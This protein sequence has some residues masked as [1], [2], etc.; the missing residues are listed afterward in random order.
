MTPQSPS[1]FAVIGHPIAHS[2][3]PMIHEAFAHQCGIALSYTRIDA[4]PDLFES[5]VERFFSENGRGLNVTVPFKERAF[6][7]A[8]SHLSERAREAGAV[9]TLWTRDGQLHGCNTDGVGLVRDLSRLGMLKPGQRI[10][11]L[12]AGGAARGV[13]GPLLA[14]GCEAL[15]IANRTFSKAQTLVKDWIEHHPEHASRLQASPLEDRALSEPVFS[16]PP[17]STPPLSKPPHARPWDLVINATSSSLGGQ[18][19][20]LPEAAVGHE[21]SL[22]DMMYGAQPTPFLVAATTL[23]AKKTADG[24]GMLVCQAAE[25]FRIWHGIEPQVD[26]VIDLVRKQLGSDVR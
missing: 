25:S 20:S 11:L 17:L 5:V 23:G 16:K 22:Y 10:L 18:T 2:R 12:G 15:C 8:K 21:S 4:Q 19:I 24:L 14:T 6:Q 3:S 26:P 7:M 1:N 13:V 9:N